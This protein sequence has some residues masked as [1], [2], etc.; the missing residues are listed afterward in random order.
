MKYTNNFFNKINPLVI[1]FMAIV[2]LII[3]LAIFA[4][5]LIPHN[6]LV[7]NISSRLIAPGQEFIF[8]SDNFGR[9]VFSRVIH[10]S[11]SSLYI[12]ISSVILGTIV[13]TIIGTFSAYRGGRIEIVSQR[14]MDSLLGFPSLVLA[15]VLV[16]TLGA[17]SNTIIIAIAVALIPQVARLARSHTLSI[18]EEN[19]VIAAKTIGAQSMNVIFK[20]ILPHT[21]GPIV[22]YAAG[23]VSAAIVAESA[24]SFLGLGIPPPYPSWGGML[25]EGRL[26]METAPWIT[27]FPGLFLSITAFSFA[28]LGDFLRDIVDPR[29]R[30]K[31]NSYFPWINKSSQ[32]QTKNFKE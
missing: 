19:Y 4:D 22:A 27:V 10:G 17:S 26:Y 29:D 11:R 3:F 7:Q 1:L 32:K 15:I 24:L 31:N 5:F 13:G 20:H 6:P 28:L 25:Q 12:A 2:V 9:D 16:V 14:V 18:K 30:F 23:Y 8:G 21:S